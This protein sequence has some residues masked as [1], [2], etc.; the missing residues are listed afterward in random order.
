[1]HESSEAQAALEMDGSVHIC[2]S[3]G[4]GDDALREGN[5]IAEPL[6]LCDW[7]LDW[8][9]RSHTNLDGIGIDRASDP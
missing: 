2:S 3:G 8:N 5:R 6:S 4:G 7:Q 1:M 9:R